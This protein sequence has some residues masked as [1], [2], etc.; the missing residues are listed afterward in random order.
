[1][2]APGFSFFFGSPLSHN[3]AGAPN[4]SFA[5]T[6][7]VFSG[8]HVPTFEQW[9]H[10]RHQTLQSAYES[11]KNRFQVNIMLKHF[12]PDEL[13]VKT[14]DGFVF[15]IMKHE[16]KEDGNCEWGSCEIIRKYQLPEGCVAEDVQ[17]R[18]SPDGLLT[19]FVPSVL[20]QK[21]KEREVPIILTDPLRTRSRTRVGVKEAHQKPESADE[22]ASEETSVKN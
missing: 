16:D 10:M 18:V 8:A 13:S 19:V 12:A 6:E 7:E 3:S 9:R 21:S 1:M 14:S 5:P 22:E 17:C 20:N 11:S 15:I 4:Y 2:T